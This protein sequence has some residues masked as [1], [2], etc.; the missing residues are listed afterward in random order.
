MEPR[1]RRHAHQRAGQR[2]AFV[3]LRAKGAL[4]GDGPE[5][6][7]IGRGGRGHAPVDRATRASGRQER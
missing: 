2:E 4:S 1:F 7:P 5:H 6:Q 3:R